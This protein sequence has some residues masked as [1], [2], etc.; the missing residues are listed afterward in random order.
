MPTLPD[1]EAWGIFAKIAET[2]SF[3]RAAAELKL[4]KPTVSKAV[5]R[6]EERIGTALFN[7]TSRRLSLTESG[8]QAA[9][10]AARLL[11]EGEAVEALATLQAVIPSGM[12]RMS[13]P[14]SFG[15]AN[16]APLLPELFAAYPNITIDLHLSDEIVDLIGGGF[17]LALRI[18][19][20]PDSSLR[21]RHVCRVRRVLVGAPA[22]FAN[23]EKPRSP[24]DLAQHDCLGYT[25]VPNPDRWRFLRASGEEEV[26]TLRGPLRANNAD[27][28]RPMLL[29]G[30]GLAVQPEFA[31]SEDLKAG[32]LEVLMPE[33]TMPPISVNLVTPPGRHRPARVA[34]VIE[35]L[36]RRLAAAPWALPETM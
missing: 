15:V 4:S 24:R 7:R 36:A 20:L 26:A 28:L 32:L 5:A 10:G 30:L 13:A 12:V 19:A 8:R 22:Y 16:L 17:D 21:A 35:F 14:M 27:A 23:R 34:A 18:A 9:A 29:A 1:L 25:Y 2:G 3:A 31:V 6:L 33:W 11:A